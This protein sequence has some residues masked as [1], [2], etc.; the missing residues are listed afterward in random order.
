MKKNYCDIWEK[1]NFD[2]VGVTRPKN[3]SLGVNIS[4]SQSASVLSGWQMSQLYISL[5][6]LYSY[7]YGKRVCLSPGKHINVQVL[8]EICTSSSVS[9]HFWETILRSK[10]KRIALLNKHTAAFGCSLLRLK[11]TDR[12][13]SIAFK[14]KILFRK[15]WILLVMWMLIGQAQTSYL[16]SF[17]EHS[18]PWGSEPESAEQSITSQLTWRDN[19]HWPKH[20]LFPKMICLPAKKNIYMM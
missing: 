18:T 11:T 5:C 4:F 6:S 9:H 10:G 1:G 2:T 7:I 14:C 16:N 13:A 20:K 8:P 19:P 3:K 15:L 12:F 17:A